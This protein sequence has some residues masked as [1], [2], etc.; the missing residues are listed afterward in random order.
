MLNVGQVVYDKDRKELMIFAGFEMLPRHTTA[1]ITKDG[2]WIEGGEKIRYTNF[3]PRKDGKIPFGSFIDKIG[4]RGVYF[5]IIDKHTMTKEEW[6]Y[7]KEAI[8]EYEDIG[9]ILNDKE[10]PIL[11][12]D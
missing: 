7:A 12:K 6:E 1:F 8:R 3:A 10:Q 5:G 4:I 9:W 2:D 11:N